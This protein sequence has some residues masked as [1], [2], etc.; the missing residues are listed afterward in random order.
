MAAGGKECPGARRAALASA[1]NAPENRACCGSVLA[2]LLLNPVRLQRAPGAGLPGDDAGPGG[3][4]ERVSRTG[5]GKAGVRIFAHRGNL[6]GRSPDDENSLAAL[7]V[8]VAHGF[9]VEFDVNL[10]SDRNHL[11]LAHDERRWEPHLEVE[12]FLS[13]RS[14][15]ECHALNVKHV[16]TLLSLIDLLAPESVRARFFLFDF[17]L[18]VTDLPACR[19]MMR[20][21]QERGLDV[22][23][24]LS[25]RE[26]FLEEYLGDD[27][28]RRIWLDELDGEWVG[29]SDLARLREAGKRVVYVSPELHGRR[30]LD[31]LRRRWE[32]LAAWGVHGICTDFPL[33]ARR[34]VGGSHDQSR[35]V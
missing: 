23:Y 6:R 22:A 15:S 35:S 14:G 3:A 27:T 17:E 26:P 11:V 25:D 1:S 20:A 4:M 2:W 29:G 34:V 30:D 21:M 28:V 13:S 19:Y 10:S 9:D 12:P 5:K 18:L 33:E 31:G 8:A 24:R 32:Q 16:C 7:R